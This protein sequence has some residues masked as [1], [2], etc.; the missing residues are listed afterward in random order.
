MSSVNDAKRIAEHVARRGSVSLKSLAARM[1]LTEKRV[2]L[3]VCLARESSPVEIVGDTVLF[4]PPPE[5]IKRYSTTIPEG[6]KPRTFAVASDLH[7]GSLYHMRDQMENFIGLAYQEGARMV[8]LPGDLLDGCYAHGR[9]ELS[10]HGFQ[11]QADELATTL[12]R[13][14][15]LQYRAI[16][17]NH[18]ETFERES[19]MWVHR[20]IEEVF[21]SHG[22][23]DLRVYAARGALVRVQ[24]PEHKRGLVVHLWH[25]RDKGARTLSYK[26][27]LQIEQYEPGLKPDVLLAGHWHRACYVPVRGVHGLM[28]GSFQSGASAFGRSIGGSP[29]IG[30]W[31]CDYS[32]TRD[33][34]VRSF[35]PTLVQYYHD[36]TSR[37]VM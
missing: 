10:H 17:G 12:P 8:F 18:D 11:A 22:R 33:G 24:T 37:E 35:R 19:G 14:P 32:I 36:E 25:P 15:G 4:R 13:H 6:G 29:T 34:T 30:G 27:Q 21:R 23:E 31:I 28:C 1:G 26:L 5:T 20:S 7:V 16:T 2:R 3:C 9:W